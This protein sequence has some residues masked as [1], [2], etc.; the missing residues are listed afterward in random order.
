MPTSFAAAQPAHPLDYW[1]SPELARISPPAAPS[2]L[3]QLAD[4]QGALAA[5]WSSAIGG[6]SVLILGG[7]FI[8]V[9]SGNPVWVMFLGL[10]GAALTVLGRFSWK[11]VR[12]S[13][14]DTN[15]LLITRGP[16][17]ARGGVVMVSLL[18]A[19]LGGILAAAL[20]AG[21]ARGTATIVAVVGAYVLTVALLA[22]CILVPSV[23]MGRARESFRRR[24]QSDPT[25]RTAV[26]DDLA[27]WRDPYGTAGYGP[28]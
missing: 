22:V 2:R 1:L 17:S 4:A 13:L 6:G 14:P 24:V 20:P 18:A 21:A 8:T 25:L 12:A 9:M 7:G 5:A 3:R 27:T 15:R 11:R 10:T 16:G 23:V 28:L 26:E 19:V